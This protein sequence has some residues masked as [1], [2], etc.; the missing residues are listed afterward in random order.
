MAST[1]IATFSVNQILNGGLNRL[2]KR[3]GI[4]QL[5]LHLFLIN[6]YV[7]ADLQSFSKALLSIINF[8]LIE[9][10]EYFT[11][12]ILSIQQTDPVDENFRAIGYE[13][14]DFI[15]NSLSFIVMLLALL[16]L[17]PVFATLSSCTCI[18]C[19]QRFGRNKLSHSCCNGLI[20]TLDT[21]SNLSQTESDAILKERL[22]RNL[23]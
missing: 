21:I 13:N 7:D 19:V 23:P 3:V 10:S 11:A 15:S 14:S 4:L 1:G 16:L 22:I 17:L 9:P 20:V 8:K 12:S 18:P 5:I 6:I 2:V